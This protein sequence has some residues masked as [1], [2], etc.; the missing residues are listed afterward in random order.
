LKGGEPY[1]PGIDDLHIIVT[2]KLRELLPE[3]STEAFAL[4]DKASPH[5]GITDKKNGA[6]RG[7][8][9]R[10]VFPLP[11]LICP[12]LRCRPERTLNVRARPPE[13]LGMIDK[14]GFSLLE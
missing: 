7:R 12:H 4:F 9:I 8:E 14:E 1:D 10:W 3:N 5:N 2:W 11:K 13:Q 6:R